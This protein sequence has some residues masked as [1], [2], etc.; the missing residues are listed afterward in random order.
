[1]KADN[2]ADDRTVRP[3][4]IEL[5]RQQK[6]RV[7]GQ[8][9]RRRVRCGACG[10]K[11]LLVGDALYLGFLFASEDLDAY[12]VALTCTNPACTAPRTAITVP[13]SGFLSR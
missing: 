2:A 7:R 3:E 8:L 12:K 9:R 1:M 4:I 10:E 11:D 5:D 6:E 13:G